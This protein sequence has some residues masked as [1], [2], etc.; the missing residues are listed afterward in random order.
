MKHV[1]KI[2]MQ[3]KKYW[4]KQEKMTNGL[5]TVSSY[6]TKKSELSNLCFKRE[7]KQ[8]NYDL[9]YA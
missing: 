1:A 8:Y 7:K 2:S 9:I 5:Q 3:R 4:N 6:S